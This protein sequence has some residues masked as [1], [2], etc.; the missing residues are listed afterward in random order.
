VAHGR[1]SLFSRTLWLRDLEHPRWRNLGG[2]LPRERG[3]DQCVRMVCLQH[4]HASHPLNNTLGQ[5]GY[6]WDD[7]GQFVLDPSAEHA[8]AQQYVLSLHEEFFS[9]TSKGLFRDQCLGQVIQIV[10]RIRL[11]TRKVSKLVKAI[12]II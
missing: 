8:Y 12:H 7:D 2:Y 6:I 3:R 4:G 9:L 1:T 5:W 11:R 10:L